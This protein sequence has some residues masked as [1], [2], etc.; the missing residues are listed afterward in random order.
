VTKPTTSLTD[1]LSRAKANAAARDAEKAA[2]AK[3]R[4]L[5]KTAARRPLTA[6]ELELRERADWEPT[7]LVLILDVWKCAC[8]AEGV[9]PG[10]L[11][12]HSQHRRMNADRL[13]AP[14]FESQ[15]DQGLPRAYKYEDRI[16]ALCPDC[17]E[18]NGFLT[19]FLPAARSAPVLGHLSGEGA[20]FV[21]EWKQLLQ[22]TE[23]ED[24]S[25]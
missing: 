4:E 20:G 24:D 1:L 14:R 2:E 21:S 16:V 6:E 18:A 25:V 8:G 13:L 9:S 22:P 15:I 23:D 12:I 5:A 10:G 3:S 19:K 7:T 17:C 11:M